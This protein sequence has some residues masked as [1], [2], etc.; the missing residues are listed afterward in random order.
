MKARRAKLG[1]G[2]PETLIAQKDL[3]ACIWTR[4]A[5]RMAERC[6]ATSWR[7]FAGPSPRD[8]PLY[9]DVA[10]R[11][12]VLAS[13]TSKSMPT[14]LS[15]LREGLSIIEKI[16]PDDWTTPSYRSLLGEALVRQKSFAAAENLLLS[17]ERELAERSSK[18][19]APP[20]PGDPPPRGG[21]PGR[22]L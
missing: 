13:A 3:P 9:C 8:D 6:P 1:D 4:D 22:A 11:G 7:P 5:T 18:N 20:A 19:P 17:S 15:V 2:H 16:Q 12:S 21:S 10:G 14:A